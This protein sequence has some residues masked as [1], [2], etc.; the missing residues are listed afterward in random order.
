M[1]IKKLCPHGILGVRDCKDCKKLASKRFHEAHK[2]EQ[3]ER[4]KLWRLNNPIKAKESYKRWRDANPE[5]VKIMDKI[6]RIKNREKVNTYHRSPRGKLMRRNRINRNPLQYIISASLRNH[7]HKGIVIQTNSRELVAKFKTIT[8]C[9]ICFC[10]LD[11]TYYKDGTKHINLKRPSL[12]RIDNETIITKD[13][14]QIICLSCNTTKGPRTM[15][16]FLDYCK[17]VSK[18]TD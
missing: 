16:E 2:S 11:L 17:L 9:Q 3:N 6:K 18:R 4:S 15:K 8:H 13:N 14:V 5:K 7:R 12:D 10:E 1:P